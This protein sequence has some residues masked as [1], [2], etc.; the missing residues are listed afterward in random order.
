MDFFVI[1]SIIIPLLHVKMHT[2]FMYETN[3]IKDHKIES[4]AMG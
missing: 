2:S 3:A 1:K 4:L